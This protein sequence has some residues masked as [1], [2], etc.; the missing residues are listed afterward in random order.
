MEGRRKTVKQMRRA[1]ER[2]EGREK[3]RGRE[4]EGGLRRGGLGEKM[5]DREKGCKK[6]GGETERE[7]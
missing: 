2:S 3:K 1:R 7:V 4:G 6:K 5:G